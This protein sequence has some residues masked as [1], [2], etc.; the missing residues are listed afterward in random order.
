MDR[1]EQVRPEDGRHGRSGATA[2]EEGLLMTRAQRSETNGASSHAELPP[3]WNQWPGINEASRTLNVA[4]SYISKKI[5]EGALGTCIDP[6]GRR[7]I[8][9]RD[10]EALRIEVTTA[11]ELELTGAPPAAVVTPEGFKAGT[12]LV[13]QVQQHHER[14]MAL[15]T[16]GFGALNQA[17]EARIASLATELGR[18]DERIALLEQERDLA[19]KDRESVL[20]EEHARMLA[21]RSVEATEARKDKALGILGDRLGPILT[22]KLGLDPKMALGA[23]LLKTLKREQLLPLL[24]LPDMLSPEQRA[25]VI[26]LL[27]PLTPEEQAAIAPTEPPP[28]P[29]QQ[30]EGSK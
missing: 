26:K 6:E 14:M 23:Q 21:M 1:S 5:R 18:R 30:K 29:P 25:L 24:M 10:V 16:A 2:G 17:Q 8:D 4:H 20:S 28:A 15:F 7:R 11:D 9:P 19:S 22:A 12:D 13:R 3:G 27:E